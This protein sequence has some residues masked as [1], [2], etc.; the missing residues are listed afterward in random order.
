MSLVLMCDDCGFIERTPGFDEEVAV[1][2]GWSVRDFG[3]AC[4]VCTKKLD[5]L[6]DMDSSTNHDPESIA[7]ELTRP[8]RVK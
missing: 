7:R 6:D 3:H 5:Q 4:Q 8:L 1:K 2:L